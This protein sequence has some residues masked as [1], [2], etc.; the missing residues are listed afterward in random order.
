[1][2]QR[3]IE[4]EDKVKASELYDASGSDRGYPLNIVPHCL[5]PRQAPRELKLERVDSGPGH[6]VYLLDP[7]TG[8]VERR[9]MGTRSDA[10]L[11]AVED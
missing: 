2:V 10:H 11:G 3:S 5:Q 7:A 1:M 9:R 6:Y 4:S 8:T